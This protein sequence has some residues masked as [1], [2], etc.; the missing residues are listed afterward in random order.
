[1]EHDGIEDV[2]ELSP[3][4]EGL[5]FH[6]L[7]SPGSGIYLE[8]VTM[9]MRGALDVAAYQAAWQA[10]VDRHAVL[11]T[12][13]HWE[14]VDK[15]LQVVHR[16]VP[17][18][19]EVLDWRDADA[20]AQRE[21]YARFAHDDRMTGFDY[22]SAPLMRGR[23]IRF[24]DDEWEFFWSFSHLLMD[25][26][27]FGLAFAELTALYNAYA[28]GRSADLPPARPYRAYL[29]W[30]ARQ[31]RSATEE[32]WRRHLG[33]YT[34]PDALELGPAPAA[35][36]AEGEPTHAVLPTPELLDQIPALTAFAREHGLTLNTV[37]QGAWMIVLSRYLGRE[38]VLAGST[39]TQRPASLIGSERIMGPM[40]AT[41]PV[42]A[43]VRDDAELIDWLRELQNDMAQAREHAD[44]S[45]TDLRRLA[46]LPGN[47]PL[48]ELDLAFENVPVPEM[49]LHEVELV[50]S[51][52]DGRPHFPI[53]MIVMPGEAMPVPRLVYDQTRFTEAAVRRLVDQF[54]TTLTNMI[55][56]PGLRLGDMDIMPTEQWRQVLLD[57]NPTEE[58]PVAA[59][60]E[61]FARSASAAP[62]AIAVVCAGQR[63][64][65][66]D[67]AARAN[68]LAHHLRAIGVRPGDR[69]GL[70]LHRSIDMVVGVLGVLTAGAAYVPLDL[71]H[72][73]ERMRY[74]LADADVTALVTHAAAAGAAPEFA[75]ALV[76][77]D[78]DA[79]AI[80]AQP[81]EPPAD[82]PRPDDVAY[83]I[84]TSG[85]TGRPKGV[86]V[87][88]ANVARLVAGAS[89]LMELGADDAW[90]MVHSYAF[91]VSVF[92][93]WG[94]FH[95]GARLVVVPHDAV[96][97][98]EALLA[99]LHA[100][101]V[102]VFSQTPS[103]FRQ[104]MVP[105]L[106]E[107]APRLPLRYVIFAGEYL[108]TPLLAPWIDRYG[109][110]QPRLVNMYG[111]TE[112]TVHS[113]YRRITRADLTG[114][115]RSNVG[116][117][118]PDL[119]IYLLDERAM[120][121]P[122]G[123]RGEI[124]VGGAGVTLGYR[125]LPEL[126]AQRFL[127]D[128]YAGEGEHRMYRSGDLARWTDDGE[129]EF[130]G[131]ADQQVKIRGFRV[132][133]GEIEAVLR[134]RPEIADAVVLP[135]EIAGDT[136][137]VA[138]LVP[139][140]GAS[141]V[142]AELSNALRAVLPEYMVPA[143]LVTL[144]R[145]PL[146]PN[147]K[148]DRAALPEFDGA[149][150]ALDR[151]YVAPRTATEEAVA[152][153][154][155]ELLGVE[156][157]GVHDDFFALGGHSLLATRVAFKLRGVLGVEVPV[158]AIFDHPVLERLAG[159][160]DELTRRPAASAPTIARQPR[161]AQRV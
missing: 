85:S 66:A 115:I 160:I 96:R 3:I 161:V 128:L 108:D 6:N 120:P 36:L 5:L 118:L 27:S 87:S 97:D 144:D 65:Y 123:M 46:D 30:W 99:L 34:A 104:F 10:I 40:L 122:P 52:Y 148:T 146:T 23:L 8:Q 109:D 121:V 83:L 134:D 79:P 21:R 74:I 154:W 37:M 136:R 69:V 117:P 28:T 32:F 2:Y 149:R 145:F 116:R 76:D 151:E 44:I 17:F 75:G 157:A 29:S 19:I 93:M 26:W 124:H 81:A 14:G 102:T 147:G 72:P 50:E 98:P 71:G 131:R 42:R 7:Y 55:L 54:S 15:A 35:P 18:P 82:G 61:L 140:D 103:A 78:A 153:A 155:R 138:Y 105:A 114:P 127:P 13:F 101:R 63:L 132:E 22:G 86:L 77:L 119:R 16:D 59:L 1:M 11:R 90:S 141:V 57:W 152:A 39:G 12:G 142:D 41:M 62:D 89:T 107:R 112:T 47:R 4:Q 51:T 68:R 129:L 67:L 100:E 126:T 92:E 80:A 137:L 88:H 143:H 33:G 106:A 60:P 56:Y 158:R 84:Y 9:R 135:R 48:F 58:Q 73:A 25:G 159:A 111:I 70:C 43:R 94:A 91:D 31:D 64:S 150:A 133:P 38:D 110:D 139:A 95:H 125:N 113:T 20:D 49:S 45:L 130:L 24:A 53:T 156:K